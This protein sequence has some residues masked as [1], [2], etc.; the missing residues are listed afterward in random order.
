MNKRV[1]MESFT[2]AIND[3]NYLENYKLLH[4]NDINDINFFIQTEF[5]Y[6][7]F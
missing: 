5:F 3:G 4:S 6:S 7:T 1:E 2:I